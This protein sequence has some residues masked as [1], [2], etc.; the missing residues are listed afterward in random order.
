MTRRNLI[1]TLT[2]ILLAVL[3]LALNATPFTFGEPELQDATQQQQTIDAGINARFTQTAQAL[4]A[5]ADQTQTAVFAQTLDAAFAQAQ[6]AT[7]QAVGTVNWAT[8]PPIT[9]ASV[10]QLVEVG[11]FATGT[12]AITQVAFDAAGSVL[13]TASADQIVRQWDI[14]TGAELQR[15]AGHT[16]AITALALS[17]TNTLLA[18]ASAD[19][20]VRLWDTASGTQVLVLDQA[21]S[22]VLSLAFNTSGTHLITGHNQGELTLWE[23]PQGVKVRTIPAHTGAVNGAAFRPPDD[24]FIVS[25]GSDGLAKLWD[26]YTGEAMRD[27][28]DAG[29]PLLALAFSTDGLYTAIAA[30]QAQIHLWDVFSDI[31]L[32]TPDDAASYTSLAFAPTGQILGAGSTLTGGFR[33]W[34]TQTGT[35]LAELL[36]GVPVNDIAFN[37][38]GTLIATGGDVARLW[39]VAPGAAIAAAPTQAPPTPNLPTVT[40]EPLD[41]TQ[42][43]YMV[44]RTADALN[45]QGTAQALV[46]TTPTPRPPGYP[47]DI[48]AQLQIVEQEFEHGRMIW[49]RHNRQ[50]WVLEWDISGIP[51]GNWYCYNDTFQDGEPETD[52]AIEA[53]DGMSQP[54]RGFG[55]VWRNN[56]EIRAALGWATG[57]ELEFNT[58]SYSYLINGYFDENN[59]FVYGPGE[60]R[61]STIIGMNVAL[62]EEGVRGDCVG[63]TWH[64]R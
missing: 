42:Q 16:G 36:P 57:T 35:R 7:A 27:L 22:T 10:A 3:L 13:F 19:N 49:L 9:P 1:I 44:T 32:G 53:P 23:V 12:G 29:N 41:P 59:N 8:L 48:T 15:Y 51:G 46:N 63:G 60:H 11:Q 6:T 58:S 31:L 38:R 2:G 18:T 28:D 26:A 56:P 54:R 47:D 30:E 37:A 39:A 21:P 33:L 24:R 62:F 25:V 52:P 34:D 5:P 64:V 4:F 50:I 43:I 45:V 40:S 55:K 14:T 20:T 61:L 17:P